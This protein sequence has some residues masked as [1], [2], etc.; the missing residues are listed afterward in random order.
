M[1]TPF[2][3]MRRFKQQLTDEE[4]KDARRRGARWWSMATMD[5]PTCSP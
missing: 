3:E 4:C 5:I 2:R 1:E